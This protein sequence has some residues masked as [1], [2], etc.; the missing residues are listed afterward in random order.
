MTQN[1]ESYICVKKLL[2]GMFEISTNGNL[3]FSMIHI[4]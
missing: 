2:D 1:S 4:T 3:F